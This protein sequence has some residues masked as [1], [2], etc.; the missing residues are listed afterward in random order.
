M[1]L[2]DL[3]LCSEQA[4]LSRYQRAK[5]NYTVQHVLHWRQSSTTAFSFHPFP[6]ESQDQGNSTNPQTTGKEV[7]WLL[8]R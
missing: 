2:V 4:S 8:D 7:I 3:D 5:P 1:R 6:K